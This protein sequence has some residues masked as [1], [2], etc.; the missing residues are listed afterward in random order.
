MLQ[1]KADPSDHGVAVAQSLNTTSP[2][3]VSTVFLRLSALV[4]C[5]DTLE[6]IDDYANAILPTRVPTGEFLVQVR[7]VVRE[8]Q[9]GLVAVLVGIG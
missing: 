5:E 9:E 7:V 3:I 2:P 4:D 8:T 6:W 1:P